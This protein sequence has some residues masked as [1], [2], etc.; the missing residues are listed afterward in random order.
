MGLR[1]STEE[2]P[3]EY[4]RRELSKPVDDDALRARQSAPPLPQPPPS[5]EPGDAAGVSEASL[6]QPVAEEVVD[7]TPKPVI[8]ESEISVAADA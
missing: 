4:A 6:L 1:Q 3:A 8:D 5:N 7:E 2:T